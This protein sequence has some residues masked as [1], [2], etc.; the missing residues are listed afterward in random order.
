[1]KLKHMLLYSSFLLLPSSQALSYEELSPKDLSTIIGHTYTQ[2]ESQEFQEDR[3]KHISFENGSFS[4]VYYDKSGPFYLE[5]GKISK[6]ESGEEIITE[7]EYTISSNKVKFEVG[8]SSNFPGEINPRVCETLV[9][10]IYW[11][12]KSLNK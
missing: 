9:D 11:K 10:K 12:V 4:N 8:I 2:G 1:M 3:Y 5:L 7:C 6:N